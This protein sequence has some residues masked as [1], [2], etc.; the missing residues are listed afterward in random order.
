MDF[1]S[2]LCDSLQS[3]LQEDN[4]DTEELSDFDLSFTGSGL[5]DVPTDTP[6]DT[7]TDGNEEASSGNRKKKHVPIDAATKEKIRQELTGPSKFDDPAMKKSMEKRAMRYSVAVTSGHGGRHLVELGTS[8]QATVARNL[9]NDVFTKSKDKNSDDYLQ[10]LRER[11]KSRVQLTKAHTIAEKSSSDG[12]IEIEITDTEMSLKKQTPAGKSSPGSRNPVSPRDMVSP[13]KLNRSMP[14]YSFD[15]LLSEEE[16]EEGDVI[17]KMLGRT[18]LLTAPSRSRK[19]SLQEEL[20]GRTPQVC[21]LN[22]I[23]FFLADNL[24]LVHPKLYYHS[25]D[26]CYR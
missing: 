13:P 1:S 24:F 11:K 15:E 17:S 19:V 18:A 8:V 3:E 4:S 23:L 25:V 21:S 9:S 22:C 20:C 10:M 5:S 26:R 7:Q 6:T 12:Q 16:K 2:G 14:M